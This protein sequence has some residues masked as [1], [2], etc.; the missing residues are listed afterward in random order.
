MDG[1]E[2]P[3]ICAGL[4]VNRDNRVA[5]KIRTLP[6]P[7]IGADDRRRE[8]QVQHPAA[9]IERE[10]ERPGIDAQPVLPAVAVPCIVAGRARWRHRTELPQPGAGARVVRPRIPDTPNAAG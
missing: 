2:V 10:I 9:L 5:E 6:I 3:L 7:A 4:S 8:R 1:L